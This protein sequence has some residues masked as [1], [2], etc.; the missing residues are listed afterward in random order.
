MEPKDFKLLG[1]SDFEPPASPEEARLETFPNQHKNHFLIEFDC[2]DFTSL[3]PV[4]QQ[5]DYAKILIK[6]I[7]NERCIETK[8]LKYYLQS[9]RDQKAFNEQIVNAIASDLVKACDPKWIRV[10]GEFVSRGGIALTTIVEY[11][12]LGI[13]NMIPKN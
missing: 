11:P 8:S 7:P 10:R 1:K 3:C 6:Y 2:L 13:A 5:P 4:T 12:D 9:F